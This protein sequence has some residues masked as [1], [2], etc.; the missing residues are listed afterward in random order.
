MTKNALRP[1]GRAMCL[2]MSI[3][4]G[5]GPVF[6]QQSPVAPG[7]QPAP[8]GAVVGGAVPYGG[9]VVGQ[10]PTGAAAGQQ[11]PATFQ[12][13]G[14]DMRGGFGADPAPTVQSVRATTRGARQQ[15][16]EFFNP[17]LGREIEWQEV[18]KQGQTITSM[19]STPVPVIN[20]LDQVALA[21]NWNVVS[22]ASLEELQVRVW[23]NKVQADKLLEILR[24]FGVYYSFDE[25]IQLLRVMTVEEHIAARFGRIERGTFPIQYA[26]VLDM[27]TILGALMSENGKLIVD[28]RTAHLI[29]WDTPDNLDVMRE[30]VER[31]DRPLEESV[32][33]LEYIPA[34]AVVDS[35]SNIMSEVGIAHAD[36]RSNRIIVR[37]LPSRQ[38]QIAR[39][40]RAL[41]Q[42]LETRTWTLNYV[43]PEVIFERLEAVLPEELARVS[44]DEDTHQI[45]VT[46]IPA[47][48]EQVDE[49]VA[50]WD[51]KPLQ[52]QIQAYLI[53][54][55]NNVARDL[56]VAW[57]Y[58]DEV[59]GTSIALQHGSAN[60]TYGVNDS[61]Q[62]LTVGTLPYRV[63]LINFWTGNPITDAAGETVLDPEFKGSRI[64]AVVN[65]MEEKGWVKVLSRPSVTV[66]DGEE[67]TFKDTRD[68]PYQTFSYSNRGLV[69]DNVNFNRVLPSTVDFV[70]VGTILKVLPRINEEGNIMMEINAEDSD[71]TDERVLVGDQTSTIPSK[72]QSTAETV[73]MVH[74][75]QTLVIGGLRTSRIEDSTD[76]F[77]ILGEIPL[78]GNLF[79]STNKNNQQREIMIF[80]T[81]TI[82][83][84]HTVPEAARLA[85]FEEELH[86]DLRSNLKPFFGRMLDRFTKHQEIGVSIGQTGA[87]HSEGERV[88]LET[89][90]RLL[91]EIP[92]PERRTVIIR[93]HPRAPKHLA[94]AVADA[95]MLRGM[96]VEFD[97]ITAPFVPASPPAEPFEPEPAGLTPTH[98]PTEPGDAPA[99]SGA[100]I[101]RPVGDVMHAP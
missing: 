80:L 79:K 21:T 6:A 14:A 15:G 28:P 47:Q 73:V 10:Q 101:D 71:A 56:G 69:D 92:D 57:N 88:D 83:D 31:L 39:V 17:S 35:I 77:P 32:F 86:E 19:L 84:E 34:E 29:V 91:A 3:L 40:I 55:D 46:A 11:A 95:A 38:E 66:S 8:G 63:P 82:V 53:L 96:N 9:G 49:V 33:E 78:V 5:A 87:M 93:E 50:A 26:N 20:L 85:D 24:F 16:R 22:S 64:S 98:V 48:L 36:P 75:Q 23:V 37:D 4:L 70:E 65:F 81:P 89:M 51:A 52:V 94:N 1:M 59:D 60:P 25:Q 58:F 12:A 54:A 76:Q 67:A 41:D 45:S 61:G 97:R 74:D 30:T 44:I 43:E 68:R 18:P 90:Q 42:P 99:V 62:R 2:A 7:P 27:E 72:S 100:P 13:P